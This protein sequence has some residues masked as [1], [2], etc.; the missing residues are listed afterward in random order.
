MGT[1]TAQ[2]AGR[3]HRTFPKI[4]RAT[5][6]ASPVPYLLPAIIV[7]AVL[8][9]YPLIE[10]VEMA[11]SAVGPTDLLSEWDYVGADNFHEVLASGVFWES[12]RATALLTIGLV[13][14]NLIIGYLGA[15]VLA[16][17]GRLA[18]SV[19]ALTVFVWALPPLV[20]G[21]LWKFMLAGDGAVNAGLGLLGISPQDWLSSPQLALV[22]VT[23]VT[24]WAALPFA[25]LVIRGGLLGISPEVL[26][27]ADIDGAGAIRKSISVI[28]PL[29]RPT[30]G[31]LL[32]LTIFYSFRSFDFVFVMTSGGP[33]RVTNT[34]P[35]YAYDTAFT[36]YDF[37]IGSTIATL[38]MIIVASL[39]VPY[40]L[41]VRK[42]EQ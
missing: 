30:F 26:E 41:G 24:A 39:A 38:A 8:S 9:V 35:F 4:P 22:S 10:M 29:L 27:A 16:R 34:L 42:E 37:S 25:I 11:L 33:G 36:T 18:S 14:S 1:Q 28:I 19:L 7:V 12:V 21:S 17:H 32:V 6:R 40:V 13:V 2:R 3:R 15:M 23:F 20:S 31:V 5:R